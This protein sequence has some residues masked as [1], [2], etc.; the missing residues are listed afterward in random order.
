MASNISMMDLMFLLTEKP[1]VPRHVGAVL[2][3]RRPRVGGARA[4]REI[5]DAY[6]RPRPRPPFNRIPVIDGTGLPE[7]RE[8]DKID[9][10]QHVLHLNLSAPGTD[11]QL[12]E[13]IAELREPLL[14]RH[15]SGWQI[16]V[17]EGLEGDRFAI[18]HKCHYRHHGGML[19]RPLL[20]TAHGA[21]SAL[22]RYV[23]SPGESRARRRSR[24][25]LASYAGTGIPAVFS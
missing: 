6:R 17:T 12:H 18:Y 8:V 21:R 3:F 19:R 11:R 1:E 20:P 7:W 13:L 16:C 14:D 10:S 4:A 5:V 23:S 2:M 24:H 25:G 9:P 22:R 15:R